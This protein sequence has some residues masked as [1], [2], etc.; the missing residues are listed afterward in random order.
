[1][2]TLDITAL[3]AQIASR[4]LGPIY[5]FVG[6]DTRLIDRIVDAVEATVDEPDRPFAVERLYA[7]EAGGEPIDIAS[8]SRVFPM[9]GDRRIVIVLRAERL[10]KPKRAAKSV[11]PDDDDE[12][13]DQE[14]SGLDLSALEDYV[15]SPAGSTT[16][17]FVATELDRSR[18]FTKRLLEAAQVVVFGGLAADGPFM[19]REARQAA[20]ELARAEEAKAGRAIEPAAL[21]E[22]VERSGTDI[23]KLRADL[24]RLLLYSEGH[25]RI[26]ID[27]VRE[28]VTPDGG[29]E[30]PWGVVNAI[31]LGDPARALRE[32]GRRLDQGDSAHALV[33]QLRWWVSTRLSEGDP[34]RVRPAIDALLRTDL[35][36]KSSGDERVLIERLVVELTGRPLPR[37]GGWR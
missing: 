20:T 8:A 23:T 13:A 14:A 36:L 5:V 3:R 30:D 1:M 32:V 21:N 34:D 35:A 11:A 10:L 22:L 29:G 9:L 33:G 4:A 12:S 15:A 16:L 17:V 25:T 19:R 28:V 7:A 37:G 2:P 27:D 18:R 26:S 31:A 24:E 6:E